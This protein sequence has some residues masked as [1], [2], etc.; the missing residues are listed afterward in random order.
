M[1]MILELGK[2]I[3]RCTMVCWYVVVLNA[4]GRFPGRFPL[5]YLMLGFG[6]GLEPVRAVM[7]VILDVG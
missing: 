7:R 1:Y 5:A 3:S 2:L 4:E 6:V